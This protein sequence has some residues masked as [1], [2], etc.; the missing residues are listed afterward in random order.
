LA[1]LDVLE[2]EP[3]AV[4][5]A[6]LMTVPVVQEAHWI[7]D[8][9]CTSGT[10]EEA[11]DHMGWRCCCRMGHHKGLALRSCRMATAVEQL[12]DKERHTDR[13]AQPPN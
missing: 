2:P 11:L 4:D 13:L 6:M 12:W 10:D 7:V 8:L 1:D 9:D 3:V 5:K